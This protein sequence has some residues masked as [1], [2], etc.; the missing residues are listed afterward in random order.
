MM[1]SLMR[2]VAFSGLTVSQSVVSNDISWLIKEDEGN[3]GDCSSL[4]LS[5]HVPFHADRPGDVN[6]E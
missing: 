5:H 3:G 6:A 4:R 2:C 1:V